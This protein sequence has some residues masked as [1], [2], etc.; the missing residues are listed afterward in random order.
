MGRPEP[1]RRL[2]AIVERRE[3]ERETICSGRANAHGTRELG[4]FRVRVAEIVR[5]G[6][7]RLPDFD[8]RS[9]RCPAFVRAEELDVDAELS[10]RGNDARQRVSDECTTRGR[11]THPFAVV[12][13]AL[14]FVLLLFFFF[15][16]AAEHNIAAVRDVAAQRDASR[17]VH[18]GYRHSV[19]QG[20]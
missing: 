16:C 1:D 12:R 19:L 10:R 14:D 13:A 9:R 18:D 17:M 7:A 11:D 15:S 20:A 3:A 5:K 8:I 4:H 2:V 6:R